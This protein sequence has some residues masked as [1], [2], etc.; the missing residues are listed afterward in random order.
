MR[1][2]WTNN[3]DMGTYELAHPCRAR[4]PAFAEWLAAAHRFAH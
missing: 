4:R 3:R 2:F 1:H